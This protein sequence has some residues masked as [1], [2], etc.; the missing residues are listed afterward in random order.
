MRI[1]LGFA[2]GWTLGSSREVSG[3]GLPWR[4][5]YRISNLRHPLSF[6]MG[7]GLPH[8][9]MLMTCA[10]LGYSTNSHHNSLNHGCAS[11]GRTYVA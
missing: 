3:P 2:V 7:L 8:L 1:A 5:A 6:L 11:G 10:D 9:S 4:Q